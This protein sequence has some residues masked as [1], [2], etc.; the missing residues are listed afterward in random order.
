MHLIRSLSLNCD[1]ISQGASHPRWPPGQF[2]TISEISHAAGFLL[3]LMEG[4]LLLDVCRASTS[5]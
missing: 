3:G 2:R 4:L 1:D 5:H